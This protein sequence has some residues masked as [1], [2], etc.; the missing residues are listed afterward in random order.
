MEDVGIYMD[1]RS[2][3]RPFDIWP[4]GIFCGNMVYV[5]NPVLV[6]STK[7]NLA[8]L[9]HTRKSKNYRKNESIIVFMSIAKPVFSKLQIKLFSSS[10]ERNLKR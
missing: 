6:Y 7:K 9:V 10:S 5:L 3:L 8:T 4:F 2:I 1:I